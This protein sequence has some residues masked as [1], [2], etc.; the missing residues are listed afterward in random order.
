MGAFANGSMPVASE[1]NGI[2]I[3]V[4]TW[5]IAAN[6]AKLTLS[7]ERLIDRRL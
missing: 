6:Q 4:T 1:P 3:M 2:A 5:Q 7:A